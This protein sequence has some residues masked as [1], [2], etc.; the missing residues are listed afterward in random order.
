MMITAFSIDL[1]IPIF[2]KIIVH[3]IWILYHTHKNVHD[4][5]ALG[6]KHNYDIPYVLHHH[7][8]SIVALAVVFLVLQTNLLLRLMPVFYFCFPFYIFLRIRFNISTYSFIPTRIIIHHRIIRT[9][10]IQV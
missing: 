3:I 5:K 1:L 8:L 7:L 10:S 2:F 9:V 4:V 6:H